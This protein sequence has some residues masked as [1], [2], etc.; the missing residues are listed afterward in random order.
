MLLRSVSIANHIRNKRVFLIIIFVF[1]TY[2]NLCSLKYA[3]ILIYLSIYPGVNH[4][5]R[6]VKL[7]VVIKN[8]KY[9]RVIS[10]NKLG[11]FKLLM[12]NDKLKL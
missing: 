5:H 6:P 12:L 11:K 9:Y 7:D 2:S 8:T 1:I 3:S 10:K 4:I